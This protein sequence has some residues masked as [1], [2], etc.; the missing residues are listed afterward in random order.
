MATRPAR[1]ATLLAGV[2][3]IGGLAACEP[4]P[5]PTT[6]VATSDGG[7]DANPGDGVCE[8]TVGAGNCSLQAAVAEGNATDGP[9][10]IELAL[11]ADGPVGVGN[12]VISNPNSTTIDAGDAV[13]AG[14]VR[15]TAGS[16]TLRNATVQGDVP[17]AS[18]GAAV[19]S[20]GTGL[21]LDR[22]FI[23]IAGG[24]GVGAAVC[25]TGDLAVVNSE[26]TASS[27][28]PM[29]AAGGN[30]VIYG[31]A[32]WS[33]NSVSLRA[34]GTSPSL[35]V[36]NSIVGGLDAPTATG[37][38]RYSW[39]DR[40][41]TGAVDVAASL[42]HC[43]TGGSIS[44]GGYNLDEDG[45]CGTPTS[46][47]RIVDDIGHA[48]DIQDHPIDFVPFVG[49]ARVGAIPPG[50]QGLCDGT[51]A[52]DA[53]GAPR[54]GSRACDIGPYQTQ[55][56][57]ELVGDEAVRAAVGSNPVKVNASGTVTA[58]FVDDGVTSGAGRW[59]DDGSF[60]S[61]GVATS[62]ANDI[63]DDGTVVGNM[64]VEG[65]RRPMRWAEGSTP[66]TVTGPNG[67]IPGELLAIDDTDGT[68]VG[69]TGG[70]TPTLWYQRPGGTPTALPTPD[71]AVVRAVHGGVA[72]GQRDT[73]T[74][75]TAVRWALDAGTATDL[76]V[77]ETEYGGAADAVAHDIGSDGTIVG[78]VDGR[79]A[80]WNPDGSVSRVG[81]R[82]G[83]EVA[84]SITA[85][86]H[87]L[88]TPGSNYGPVIA[89]AGTDDL[90]MLSP[91]LSTAMVGRDL[92][93]DGTLVGTRTDGT[94]TLL[95]RQRLIIGD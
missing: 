4:A 12:L 38:V 16:L 1:W 33:P 42:V 36:V 17:T 67:A 22:V 58:T 54:D 57:V 55:A 34:T 47:D 90:R 73:P 61:S 66:E 45:S 92:G 10:V 37:T 51:V 13:L 48:L 11:S 6:F 79:G 84:R 9:V 74:G 62:E 40:P 78:Q 56:T 91:W 23:D 30:I 60:E 18:C 80:R 21:L 14:Q 71:G 44:S 87:L 20:T 7:A 32:F 39:L 95:V 46:T 83:D 50:T 82:F 94:T 64:V 28:E 59:Y 35:T 77:P 63:G 15:H 31:S 75:T 86:G 68:I 76:A 26:I 88:M 3:A 53:R 27:Y 43:T 65:V 93:D 24:E 25:A 72:V 85:S 2:V 89:P 8:M 81:L 70:S 41:T 5:E 29:L 19:H 52:T 49:A 69:L